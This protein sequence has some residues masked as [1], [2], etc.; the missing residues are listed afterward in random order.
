MKK[1]IVMALCLLLCMTACG[2]PEATETTNLPEGVSYGIKVVDAEG[3]P[4]AGA[5]VSICQDK[6]G[7]TCYMPVKTDENG[8]AYFYADMV[9]V[10]DNMKFRV[11][12][13]EGYELPL[14]DNGDIRYTLIPNGT[15]Q[16]I[17]SLN[18][19]EN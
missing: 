12:A 10:Q 17:I 8:M 19:I 11:L 4:I 3:N 16:M 15:V 18:K 2:Q 13:A 5:M 9:P 6:E 14:D 1:M 7:G